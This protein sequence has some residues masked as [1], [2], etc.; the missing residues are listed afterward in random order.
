M[1]KFK[2]DGGKKVMP[3]ITTAS[4]PD[5]MFMLLFFFMVST[6]LRQN[7]LKIMTKL[8]FAT[9]ITKLEKKSLVSY[10]FVGSPRKEYQA[11]LG[12]E[13]RIQLDDNFAVINDIRGYIAGEWEKRDE[14]DRPKMTVSL[15]ADEKTKMGIINEIKTQLRKAEALKINYSAKKRIVQARNN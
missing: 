8:P 4:L 2:P 9:E 12:T 13:S 6:T 3:Q 1:S 10:I 14:A 15:K 5:I 11:S 7:E